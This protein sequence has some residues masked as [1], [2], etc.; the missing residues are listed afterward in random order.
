VTGR[1]LFAEFPRCMPGRM[2]LAAVAGPQAAPLTAYD[3]D[4]SVLFAPNYGQLNYWSPVLVYLARLQRRPIDQYLALWDESLGSIQRTRFITPHRKEELLFGYGPYSYIW[5]DPTV[6]AEVEPDLPRS[7][8]FPEP[9]VNEAYIRSS[10]QAGDI[11]AGMLKGSV[12]IH[13]GGRSVFVDRMN[14]ADQNKPAPPV[15]QLLVADD[16]RTATIRCVGPKQFE[17]GEQLMELHR[18]NR[19]TLS[20][21]TA[22]P[23]EFWCMDSPKQEGNRLA[24]PD[25]VQLVVEHGKITE[26]KADG[27]H[28]TLVHFGGMKWADPCPHTFPTVRVEPENGVVALTVERPTDPAPKE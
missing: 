20:R 26:F 3:P 4:R 23:I 25:G 22:K 5:C 19:L 16:G 28:E 18:P 10:Y 11:V 24:W 9:E 6:P 7:F 1:D 8:E 2:A 21:H 15:E 27:Y 12:I 17:I 14:T 13:A